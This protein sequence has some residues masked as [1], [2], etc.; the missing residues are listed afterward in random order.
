MADKK[1]RSPPLQ[2]IVEFLFFGSRTESLLDRVLS[3][4]SWAALDL[5]AAL[6][7]AVGNERDWRGRS[8][9]YPVQ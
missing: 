7:A 8:A 3:A 6:V 5:V 1:G 9:H 2:I 4:A